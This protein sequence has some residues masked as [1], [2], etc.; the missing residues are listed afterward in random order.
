M[1]PQQRSRSFRR[2]SLDRLAAITHGSGKHLESRPSTPAR[3]VVRLIASLVVGLL[4]AS[5]ALAQRTT[6][7]SGPFAVHGVVVDTA[8]RTIEGATITVYGVIGSAKT[9]RKGEFTLAG[10]PGGTHVFQAV[11][12]G[13]KPQLTPIVISDRTG[14]VEI[15]MLHTIIVLDSVVT[16][17]RPDVKVE[18]VQRRQNVISAAE[19]AGREL[20]GRNAMEALELLRPAFF[21]GRGAPGNAPDAARRGQLYVRDQYLEEKNGRPACIGV[22]ACDIDSRLTVSINEGPLGSADVLTTL[23]V[24]MI[25]EMKYLQPADATARFGVVAGGGPVLIVYTK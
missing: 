6:P 17:D 1:L 10:L 5:V 3:S 18:I 14:T 9:D 11:A 24:L 23:S 2:C 8:D 25:R 7:A 22:R 15:L 16:N 4:S 20:T 13:Y 19:L 12:L 21:S